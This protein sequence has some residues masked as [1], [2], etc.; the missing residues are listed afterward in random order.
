MLI[1]IDNELHFTR[2]LVSPQRAA[3]DPAGEICNVIATV[4]A[5]GCN[6]VPNTMAKVTSG[7]SY[8]DI[9]RIADCHLTEV[10]LRLDLADIV[11]AIKGLTAQI[12]GQG[13]T[14]SSDGHRFAFPHKVLQRTYSPRFGDFALEFYTFVAD[15]YAPFYSLPD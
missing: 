15:N 8:H 9:K 11:N 13:T 3:S 14:S 1:D 5:Y 12:W 4:I 6:I 10:A 2:H 7:I